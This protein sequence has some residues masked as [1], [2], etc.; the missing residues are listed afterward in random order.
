MAKFFQ[1]SLV[2]RITPFSSRIAILAEREFKTVFA[3]EPE[4][5]SVAISERLFL[6]FFVH[7]HL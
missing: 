7:L 4:Y 2:S 5:L 1:A 3:S 6:F